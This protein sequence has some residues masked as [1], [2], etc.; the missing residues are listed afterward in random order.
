MGRRGKDPSKLQAVL[1]KLVNQE[2]LEAHHR[3]HR[4]TGNY[5]DYRECHIES[6][7]LLIY[8]TTATELSL[9]RTGTHSDLFK[10]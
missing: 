5:R 2:S 3:D 6:D 1:D 8:R 9:V 4:L 10:E 7:W